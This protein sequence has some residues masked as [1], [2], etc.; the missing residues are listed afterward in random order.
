MFFVHLIWKKE[1]KR[2]LSGCNAILLFNRNI[3]DFLLI[4]IIVLIVKKKEQRSVKVLV[5]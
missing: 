3:T 2:K 1:K 5:V 4:F